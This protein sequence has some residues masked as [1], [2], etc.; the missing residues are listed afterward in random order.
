MSHSPNHPSSSPPPR[1]PPADDAAHQPLNHPALNMPM[2]GS[3]TA[4]TT[5]SGNYWDVESFLDHYEEL[6]QYHRVTDPGDQSDLARFVQ[7]KCQYLIKDLSKWKRFKRKYIAIAGNLLNNKY[8]TENEYN[9]YF[10]LGIHID[11]RDKL[12]H[13]LSLRYPDHPERNPWSMEQVDKQAQPILAAD[14]FGIPI[15]QVED[16]SDESDSDSSDSEEESEHH[17]KAFKHFLE[18]ENCRGRDKDKHKS[19]KRRNSTPKP[20]RPI[21]PVS[22]VGPTRS[23]TPSSTSVPRPTPPPINPH[24]EAM[25]DI[26]K[27]LNIQNGGT[28][29][30]AAK[31]INQ[32]PPQSIRSSSTVPSNRTRV[33]SGVLNVDICFGCNSTDG[34]RAQDCPLLMDLEQEGLIMC[35]PTDGE[36]LAQAVRKAYPSSAQVHAISCS[37]EVDEYYGTVYDPYY[38]DSYSP[39]ESMPYVGASYMGSTYAGHEYPEHTPRNYDDYYDDYYADSENEADEPEIYVV[40]DYMHGQNWNVTCT[41]NTRSRTAR[42]EAMA[43]PYSPRPKRNAGMP[44]RYRDSS[45]PPRNRVPPPVSRIQPE[46]SIVQPPVPA[47]PQKEMPP[48][49][50]VVPPQSTQPVPWPTQPT[51][52]EIRPIL[53]CQ[54]F[55]HPHKI[56]ESR[57]SYPESRSSSP[58]PLPRDPKPYDAHQPVPYTERDDI[59][60]GEVEENRRCRTE[61]PPFQSQLDQAMGQKLKVILYRTMG[62]MALSISKGPTPSPNPI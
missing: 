55:P 6:L 2:R 51:P 23:H 5:F 54:P 16:S 37:A 57:T 42:E 58:A 10:W 34:H 11:L 18:K 62:L 61:R 60:M 20:Y 35:N 45:E 19:R 24:D 56:V 30:L 36:S 13:L 52:S 14:Q 46:K 43:R 27:H 4:P 25:Q 44:S 48:Q 29:G 59:V 7:R 38:L 12:E 21:P 22:A 53:P 17:R 8:I 1:R 40:S 31:C 33:G 15:Y 26:I 9:I 47:V 41:N 32:Q 39:K 50:P 49:N 3:K 28:P